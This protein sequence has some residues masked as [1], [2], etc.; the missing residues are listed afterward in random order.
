M[1]A[2]AITWRIAYNKRIT[3]ENNYEKKYY[4]FLDG[5]THFY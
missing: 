3:G 1:I 4:E 2:L 5:P